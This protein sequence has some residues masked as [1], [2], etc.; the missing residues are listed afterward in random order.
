MVRRAKVKYPQSKLLGFKVDLDA[1][2]RYLNTNP[3]DSPYQC[4]IWQDDLYLD[5]SWSFGLSS[6][7][8]RQSE[9]LSCSS[10]PWCCQHGTRLQLL[11]EMFMWG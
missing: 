1:Y 11:A 6:A 9:A 5:L 4:V 3:G 2:Y 8:Q 10:F 7:A